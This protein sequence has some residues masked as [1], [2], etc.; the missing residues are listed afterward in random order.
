MFHQ[1]KIIILLGG[2]SWLAS[3]SAVGQPVDELFKTLAQTGPQASGSADAQQASDTLM[4]HGVEILP[5]LL[6]AM[7][8]TNIVA[9]NWYRTVYQTIVRRELSKQKPQFPVTELRACV[10]DAQH[11]GRVRRLALALLDEIDPAWTMRNSVTMPSSW[12]STL[13][14]KPRR[15]TNPNWPEKNTTRRCDMRAKVSK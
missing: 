14:I 5:E 6:A 12:S 2:F 10:R 11:Q 9:A 7:D 4:T 1:S 13:A 3:S 15:P 8:T